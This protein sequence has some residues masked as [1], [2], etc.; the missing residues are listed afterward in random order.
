MSP[1][2]APCRSSIRAQVHLCDPLGLECLLPINRELLSQ[3]LVKCCLHH[4]VTT[5]NSPGSSQRILLWAASVPHLSVLCNGVFSRIACFPQAE[6]ISLVSIASIY[7]ELGGHCRKVLSKWDKS[8]LSS[9]FASE[10][11]ME[12]SCAWLRSNPNRAGVNGSKP[13]CVARDFCILQS[14]CLTGVCMQAWGLM[15]Y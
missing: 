2:V 15:I 9:H 1:S 3:T 4:S 8:E 14:S 11:K 12:P 5:Q 7:T 10:L 6:K 13:K